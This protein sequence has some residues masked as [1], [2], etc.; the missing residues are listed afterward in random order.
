MTVEALPGGVKLALDFGQRR[1]GVA[2]CD[3]DGGLAWPVTTVAAGQP[4]A[5]LEEL[6][7]RF[8]PSAVVVGW[9]VSLDGRPRSAAHKV[10]QLAAQLAG[11]IDRPVYLVDERWTTVEASRRLREAGRAARQQRQIVDQQA[12]VGILDYVLAAQRA[13]QALALRVIPEPIEGD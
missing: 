10:A 3:R 11:R 5:Q 4:W 6:V 8:Q 2:A 9:P 7:E 13:G 1:I 12:A